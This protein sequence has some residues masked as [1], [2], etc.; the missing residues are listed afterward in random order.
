MGSQ[1]LKQDMTVGVYWRTLE[2]SRLA[3]QPGLP[4]VSLNAHLPLSLLPEGQHPVWCSALCSL[5]C[6]YVV[7]GLLS[8]LRGWAS[9]CS[10]TSRMKVWVF[11][12]SFASK[13]PLLGVP[14]AYVSHPYLTC[15]LTHCKQKT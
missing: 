9:L 2:V 7:A 10:C 8:P 4:D 5:Q 14:W 13:G 11:H 3:R 1:T 15:F 6:Q 12:V